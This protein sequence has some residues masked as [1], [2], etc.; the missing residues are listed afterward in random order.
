MGDASIATMST[1]EIIY[2][3]EIVDLSMANGKGELRISIYC[4]HLLLFCIDRLG[5]LRTMR[6]GPDTRR[7]VDLFLH[8]IIGIILNPS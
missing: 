2:I 4:I 3:I 7:H 6:F 1:Q 8:H 5:G